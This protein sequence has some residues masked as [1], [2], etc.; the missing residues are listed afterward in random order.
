MQVNAFT[1]DDDDSVI[2]NIFSKMYQTGGIWA[3]N[4]D[5]KISLSIRDIFVDKEQ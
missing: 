3:I 2:K 5:G 4:K 1:V